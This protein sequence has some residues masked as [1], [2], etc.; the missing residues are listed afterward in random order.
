M[1]YLLKLFL[2]K[3]FIWLFLFVPL[4]TQAQETASW[5]GVRGEC[6]NQGNCD[7]C[8][9]VQLFIGLANWGY[10]I[11]SL[12]ALVFLIYGGIMFILSGGTMGSEQNPSRL[13]KAKKIL[14][15]TFTGL[16]LILGS[17][18]I[19]NTIIVA[20]TGNPEG[21]IFNIQNG[22]IEPWK[23]KWWEIP[24]DVCPNYS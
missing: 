21:V 16:I 7:M 2:K 9:F 19:V 24:H 12:V 5:F 18:I 4:L 13:I 8:D 14:S 6:I 10:S 22:G 3:V 23:G 15:G 11:L 20:L 17:W 1:K